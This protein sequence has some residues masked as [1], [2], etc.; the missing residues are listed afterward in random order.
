MKKYIFFFLFLSSIAI[1]YLL[2]TEHRDNDFVSVPKNKF[3]KDDFVS[4]GSKNFRLHDKDFFLLAVNYIV[5][6]QTDGNEL[7]PR[8]GVDY[9]VDSSH[10]NLTKE[11]CL[12]ELRADML[13]IKQ[14]G[15][16]TIRI[17]GMNEAGIK[18]DSDKFSPLIYQVYRGKKK[19]EWQTLT[20]TASYLKYFGAI[21]E[22]L[23]EVNNAGLKVIITLRIRPEVS[24]TEFLLD[25]MTT[26]FRNDAAVMAYDLFNEP[27]YFDKPERN[28]KEIYEVTKRWEKMCHRNAPRQLVTMGLE[29]I[30]EVHAWDP[31]TVNVDFV[32]FHPYEHE[33]EQVRN[34]ITWYNRFVKKPWIIGE[35]AIPA[36]DDSVKYETQKLFAEKTLA[37]AHNCG[38]WGYSWWQYKDVHWQKYH[39]SYMGMINWKGETHLPGDNLVVYGTVKPVAEVFQKYN[40]SGPKGECLCLSNYYNYSDLHTCRIKGKL[41]D[42]KNRPVEGGIILAWNQWWSHSYHTIT[43]PDGSF[44]L[45]G[46]FPFYHWIAS[47][48]AYSMVRGDLL[49]DTAKKDPDGIPTMDL[50]NLKIK[51]LPF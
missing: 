22:L 49:P 4:I 41:T 24:T 12:K 39:S 46:D 29:G 16:N 45:R 30:R 32:S 43:K 5:A 27:L 9:T 51:K 38:A 11:A 26:Y 17:V 31:A 48:N 34:E 20:D 36:D 25:R 18:N 44:E 21:S 13:L 15:F 8:A 35:T 1:I 40:P 33:P 7:W 3:K 50:G 14:M 42:N 10:E 6:L 19:F 47:A 2:F 23:N 28:K 37:Q